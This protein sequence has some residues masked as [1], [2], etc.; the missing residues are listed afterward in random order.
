VLLHQSTAVAIV[1]AF[2]TLLR[3]SIVPKVDC[4]FPIEGDFSIKMANVDP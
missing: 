2:S 1:A 3:S 4:S